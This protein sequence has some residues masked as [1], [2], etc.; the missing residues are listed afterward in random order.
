MTDT[1][2]WQRPV[3]L[4][5]DTLE[6]ETEA[7][8]PASA[9]DIPLEKAQTIPDQAEPDEVTTP[10]RQ[11]RSKR[12]WF[13]LTGLVALAAGAELVRLLAWGFDLHP[14]VGS[15][16]GVVVL[17]L[18]SL[19]GLEIRRGLKGSRQLANVR[20]LQAEGA[21]LMDAPTHGHSRRWVKQL[22][23]QYQ[24]T[25]LANSLQTAISQLDSSYNDREILHYLNRHALDATDRKAQ[26]CVQRYSIESGVLV[27]FSPWASFDML[28]V[29]WRNLRMLREVATIYGLAPGLLTQ[30]RLLKQVLQNLAFAGASEMAMDA[31]S[32]L[33]GSSLTAGLS[34]R[35]GQG[36]GAGLFTARTGLT[37]IKMCR[38]LPDNRQPSS[39]LSKIAKGIVQRLTIK[40]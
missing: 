24:H 2:K 10:S 12:L 7:S 30:W 28:L 11:P 27:A 39:Q 32:A 23:A 6:P 1:H 13:T 9:R 4:S 15:A 18:I 33:L 35:A 38:P 8:Q 17:G 26:Q 36:L 40:Q 31:G 34:A 25:P 37:A 29:A 21:A 22:E 5:T 14:L 20:Q 3:E 16:L 19:L